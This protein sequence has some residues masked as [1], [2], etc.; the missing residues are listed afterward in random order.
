MTVIVSAYR[1]VP[2]EPIVDVSE[3]I[4]KEALT[5]EETSLM[6]EEQDETRAKLETMG[7][8]LW[9]SRS[10]TVCSSS[11]KHSKF[12]IMHAWFWQAPI[13]KIT[14]IVFGG[15]AYQS[16][17]FKVGDEIVK[18][19]GQRVRDLPTVDIRRRLMGLEGSTVELQVR[20]RC[21]DDFFGLL[22]QW[23]KGRLGFCLGKLTCSCPFAPISF[24]SLCQHQVDVQDQNQ[25]AL[26]GQRS[27][28][29]VCCSFGE[30]RTEELSRSQSL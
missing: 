3:M 17:V 7:V 12:L 15:A 1:Q 11:T 27:P 6:E 26:H 29:V 2:I 25:T 20:L 24:P 5:L 8:G 13:P 23:W 10:K 4:E 30:R 18:V 28:Y 22:R 9:I 21:I 16:G 14:D 19:D